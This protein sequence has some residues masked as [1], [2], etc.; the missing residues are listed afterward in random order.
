MDICIDDD[1][2]LIPSLENVS[3]CGYTFDFTHFKRSLLKKQIKRYFF[4]NIKR[5]LKKVSTLHRYSY[6]LKHFTNFLAV[7]NICINDFSE[8]TSLIV[9]KYILYL[10][11]KLSSSNTMSLAFCALK[12][13]CIYG[14]ILQLDKYPKKSIFPDNPSRI[15]GVEDTL[16]TKTIS[17]YVLSQINIGLSKEQNILLKTCICIAKETGLRLSEILLLEENCVMEDFYNSPILF[18]FSHKN[19]NE[20]A[21]PISE[22]LAKQIEELQLSTESTRTKFNNKLLFVKE[23]KG[24]T[25]E[26]IV[27]T[28]YIARSELK[29]FKFKNKIID[30]SG[31]IANFSYHSFRHTLGTD[32]INNDMTPLE[33]NRY[34]GHKSM[35]S[36]GKYAKVSDNTLMQ[37]YR[38]LGCIGIKEAR[39]VDAVSEPELELIQQQDFEG[40]LPD[41]ICKKAFQ[42]EYHCKKFNLCLFC[43]KYRT[44]IRD[45]P[46]HRAHLERIRSNRAD[47]KHQ[48]GIGNEQYIQDIEDTLVAII[49]RLEELECT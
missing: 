38:K 5:A 2:W 20:R 19:N 29:E 39:V 1:K 31:N 37:E 7:N 35:H 15:F 27:Y 14:Q 10:K 8:L 41:G 49:Q 9:D 11:S 22:E 6:S 45:L 3:V 44:F 26:C 12:D 24:F 48:L 4:E 13:C 40:S 30:E 25:C 42:G 32:M 17:D 36:T 28:Q 21:V 34:L 43:N 16:K 23:K 33:V 46:T 18:T 47:Y